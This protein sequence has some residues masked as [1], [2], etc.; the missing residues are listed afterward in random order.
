MSSQLTTH[1]MKTLLQKALK[2]E[3]IKTPV[4]VEEI[5]DEHI[6]LALAFLDGKINSTQV[7]KALDIKTNQFQGFIN[8]VLK[9][10]YKNGI[11]KLK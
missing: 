8:R 5:N 3:G 4:Q 9:H 1:K 2:I 11:F 7:I 6:E 10:C